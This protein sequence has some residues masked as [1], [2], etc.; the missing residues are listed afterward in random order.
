MERTNVESR[1]KLWIIAN[2]TLKLG[3]DD[4]ALMD[5][6]RI[7]PYNAR[8]VPNPAEVKAG[9]TDLTQ[10]LWVF[11]EDPK[12]KDDVLA[13]WG[14]AMATR[15]LYAL[16]LFLMEMPRNPDH[17]ERPLMIESI[18]P[19]PVV[20]D[21]TRAVKEQQHPVLS[22][23]RTYMTKTSSNSTTDYVTVEAAFKQFQQFGKNENSQK[24][25]N[26]PHSTFQEQLLKIDIDVHRDDNNGNTHFKNYA[27]SKDVPILQGTGND[28][29]V[30]DGQS[31]QPPPAN[32]KRYR[33]HD[34]DDDAY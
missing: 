33:D 26:M 10:S 17:P 4:P 22:F 21:T 34:G 32:N 23:V 12:F 31:Y 29:Y 24:I 25:K 6:L 30:V 2:M 28:S 5:R 18:S 16:H 1:G 19:P 13:N 9:M 8:W 15:C 20:Q 3:Y 14:S 27:M 7:L 11:K